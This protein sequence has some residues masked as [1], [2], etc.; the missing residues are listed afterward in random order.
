MGMKTVGETSD[1]VYLSNI[2]LDITILDKDFF[3]KLIE[4]NDS[5]LYPHLTGKTTPSQLEGGLSI[6]RIQD[7]YDD[8]ISDKN[9]QIQ[10]STL[11]YGSIGSS[12][13][14]FIVVIISTMLCAH[15]IKMPSWL[16]RKNKQTGPTRFDSIN[17]YAMRPINVIE[18]PQAPLWC[19]RNSLP[20]ANIFQRSH[21][22]IDDG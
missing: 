1:L 8:F 17:F 20:T 3:P 15:N 9:N 18:N 14:L 2:H 11:L 6:R 13:I 5:L 22:A 21:P 12:P 16:S 10:Q 19:S 4:I 7:K